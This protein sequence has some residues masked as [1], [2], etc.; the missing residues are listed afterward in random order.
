MLPLVF[1]V[2]GRTRG[3]RRLDARQRSYATCICSHD[4]GDPPSAS[5]SR[6]AMSAL[7]AARPFTTRES[8]TL[9]TPRRAANSVTL[10]RVCR[11]N[12]IRQHFAGMWWVMHFHV[13]SMLVIVQVINTNDVRAIECKD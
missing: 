3:R 9:E 5:A 11:E 1:I 6:S 2:R 13:A 7:M 8:A 10:Q 4:S 12:R